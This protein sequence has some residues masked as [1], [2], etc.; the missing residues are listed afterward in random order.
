MVTLARLSR[1]E[2]DWHEWPHSR[3]HGRFAELQE[4]GLHLKP[5]MWDNAFRIQTGE[6]FNVAVNGIAKLLRMVMEK[7]D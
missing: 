7:D 5:E 1:I 4:E 3:I 6:G 2:D